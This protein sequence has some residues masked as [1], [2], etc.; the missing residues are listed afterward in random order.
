[1][2]RP[3]SFAWSFGS[4][5]AWLPSVGGSRKLS[6]C[7][8]KLLARRREFCFDVRMKTYLPPTNPRCSS[9]PT[10][11]T[12]NYQFP[13]VEVNPVLRRCAT[14]T[15]VGLVLCSAA[16]IGA[17]TP[18]PDGGYPI[19]NTAEGD[20]ALFSITTAGFSTAIGYLAL[21]HTTAGGNTAVGAEALFSNSTGDGNTATGNA[22]L[23]ANTT[24]SNDTAY[25]V[26]ALF[27]N[28]TGN[29]NT[30]VGFFAL[31]SNINGTDNTAIGTE[32]LFGN[33][34]GRYNTATGSGALF[35]NKNGN[36]NSAYGV[37]ALSNN[38]GGRNNTACGA[39]AL[40]ANTHGSRN[41]A[42]GRSAG[43][44]LTTGDNNIDI[45]N[46]GVAAESK[47]IRIGLP[48]DQNATYIA[49]I[50]GATVASGV[51]V[52]IDTT[53]H[54]GTITSSR[55]FKDDIQPMDRTS[56]SIFHLQPVKFRYKKELDPNGTRQFGLVAE[57]V[58]KVDPDLV[59]RDEKGQPYTVR[60][61][62]VNAMLLNEFLKAHRRAD[63]Q[64]RALGELT[65]VIA[66]QQKD[67]AALQ[68]QIETG[69]NPSELR[70]LEKQP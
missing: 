38:L 20:N 11:G 42:I 45:G 9:R 21:F 15:I 51:G 48:P 59:A 64:E 62:A 41:I 60:Y 37:S 14:L 13:A 54:L 25:G 55:R 44:N 66:K 43:E 52:V 29:N 28:N 19:A 24:G 67:I 33:R 50:A 1:M 17:V 8:Q 3:I 23:F 12:A 40:F 5:R 69:S 2:S 31:R 70:H 56:D 57:D 63:E 39:N 18:P 35:N 30:A 68:S 27:T 36:Y 26:E 58:A 65:S 34:L 4:A 61:E 49:G 22:A 16:R 53:G 10:S 47:T 32:A 7:Q 6:Q 46:G